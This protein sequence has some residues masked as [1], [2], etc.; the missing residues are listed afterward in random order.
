MA[1]KATAPLIGA[2]IDPSDPAGTL[3]GIVL[4]IIGVAVTIGVVVMAQS[5]FNRFAGTSDSIPKA[6]VI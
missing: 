1:T 3:K 5:G 6:E 4:G 2:D